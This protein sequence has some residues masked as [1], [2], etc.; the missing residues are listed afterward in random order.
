MSAPPISV[1]DP[2]AEMAAARRAGWRRADLQWERLQETANALL[3][4]GDIP[5]AARLWRRAG[6]IAL[7][8]FGRSDPRQ[9]TTLANLALSDRLSGRESRARK[10]YARARAIWGSAGRFIAAMR[11]ARRARS[12]MFHMRMEAKHWDTYVQNT[13][14][15]MSAFATEAGEALEVLEQGKPAGYRLYGRWRAEKPA[16]FDDTRKLLAAALLIGCPCDLQQMPQS[17]RDQPGTKPGYSG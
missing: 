9:A 15:R 3:R 1:S 10:R 8:W 7:L 12:S 11:I 13:R 6:W 4:A 2:A 5:G 17:G 16:V 14:V